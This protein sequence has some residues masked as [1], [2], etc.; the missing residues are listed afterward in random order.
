MSLGYGSINHDGL[1]MKYAAVC[2]MNMIQV[3]EMPL[4][5]YQ[6]L[7]ASCKL[8]PCNI[9]DIAAASLE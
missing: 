1:L 3:Y 4:S 9:N 2:H 8:P 5:V 6:A 7:Q